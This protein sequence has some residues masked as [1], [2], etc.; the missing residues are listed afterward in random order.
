ME[1]NKNI[2][3]PENLINFLLGG[4]CLFTVKSNYTQKHFTFKVKKNKDD[5][6]YKVYHGVKFDR[7]AGFISSNGFKRYNPQKIA[8]EQQAAFEW[9]WRNITIKEQLKK[10]TI[11]HHGKC[12]KCGRRLT[13]PTSIEIA[14][15]P[16]CRKELGM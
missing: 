3:K 14:L 1:E 9:L 5:S 11:Y 16:E 4:N 15:G 10:V 6:I 12:G 7:Y 13:D 8:T 2:V